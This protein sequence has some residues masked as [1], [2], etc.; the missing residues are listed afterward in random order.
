MAHWG[1]LLLPPPLL[2]LLQILRGQVVPPGEMKPLLKKL[3]A[4]MV[5]HSSMLTT[6]RYDGPNR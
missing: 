5:N 6:V 3:N 2:L 1:M 4:T